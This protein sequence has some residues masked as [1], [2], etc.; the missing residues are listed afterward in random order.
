[1]KSRMFRSL[2]IT[3]IVATATGGVYVVA[4]ALQQRSSSIAR[5]KTLND[6]FPL[7]VPENRSQW[8]E[9][10]K[11]IRLQTAVSVGVHPQPRLAESQAVIHGRRELDGYTVE[12]IYFES[13]PGFY[14]TGSLYRPT[15]TA[16]AGAKHPAVLYAHGH[17]EGGRFYV[18]PD[19]DVRQLLATGAER[20]ESAAINML[21]AA[22]VQLARMGCV[23]LQY[24]MIG[25][26]DSQ[27]I[28][29][30]RA[31][32][33]GLKGPNPPS[34]ADGWPL[35]SAI[36]EGYGQ[37]VMA[38]QTINSLRCIDMLSNLDDVDASKITITGAS[39]GGTQSFIAAC[40]D[41]RL[42]GAFPAVMVSTAM[43]GGCTCE[44]ACG[45]RIGTG[46]VEIAATIAPRPL[47]LT[48]ADDWTRDMA[49]DGFPQL[50][51]VYAMYD[52][53]DNVELNDNLQFPHNYNHVSRV[54]MYGWVNRLFD[55][56]FDE[57]ILERDFQRLGPDDLA[58]WNSDHPQPDG[59]IAFECQLLSGWAT[60]ICRS[61]GCPSLD[62]AQPK[63]KTNSPN[64][65][66]MR[67]GWKTL[68]SPAMD[69]QA[70]LTV[71]KTT[72]GYVV[73]TPSGNVVGEVIVD[74]GSVDADP[75]D[76]MAFSV[77]SGSETPSQRFVVKTWNDIF[78]AN[79][80]QQPLIDEPR[81]AAGYT[82]GY[83]AAQPVRKLAVLAAMIKAAS[84]EQAISVDC[85]AGDAFA[86][87]G[88]GMLYPESIKSITIHDESQS[89]DGWFYRAESITDA[90]FLPNSLRYGD[91]RGLHDVVIDSGKKI[92]F[93][94]PANA[95]R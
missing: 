9:R 91:L 72:S 73:K 83:N 77:P 69:I 79:P 20:F 29:H 57:P 35:F 17:W 3:V 81:Q 1:M 48:A 39:G 30:D 65:D 8:D 2:L 10:A 40:V 32:L 78:A 67:E 21:Q 53:A 34:T 37:S 52:A 86:A 92:N 54:A 84:P 80:G 71:E 16:A 31:H 59:G 87:M 15:K 45:L 93:I 26:A 11:S 7:D 4:H 60:E 6:H 13:L 41:K 68:L 33:F 94:A 50:K 55:L 95:S 36:A 18:A 19:S 63:S 62:E 58:V 51:S 82:Y 90:N 89:I 61:V 28:S 66:I 24:D 85:Q 5:L 14:V 38:L 23:V 56:G 76:A 44:N 47:G 46:N 64:L 27:Q 22:C 42:K 49:T 25:Y 88:F 12:K 74:S 70:E 43:Q 75:T